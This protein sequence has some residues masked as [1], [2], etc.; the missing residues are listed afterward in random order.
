MI[1]FVLSIRIMGRRQAG[2]GHSQNAKAKSNYHLV[3]GNWRKGN[4][5]PWGIT[6]YN[7]R[8]KQLTSNPS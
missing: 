6:L 3:L 7:S 4:T 1:S 8:E 5:Y 2:E